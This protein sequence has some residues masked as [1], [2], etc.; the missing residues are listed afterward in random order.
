MSPLDIPVGLAMVAL[1]AGSI[2]GILAFAAVCELIA[3]L[4]R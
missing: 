4:R 2:I 3:R 1:G